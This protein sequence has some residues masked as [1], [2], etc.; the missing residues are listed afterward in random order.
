M[1]I[2]LLRVTVEG[3][4]LVAD[5]CKRTADSLKDIEK[6]KII[7]MLVVN[8][9]SS[10]L[11]HIYF[12]FELKN[13]SIA[14]ARELLEHRIASHTARS[15]RYCLEKDSGFV[16][17]PGLKEEDT[18][19]FKDL[20]KNAFDNYSKMYDYLIDRGYSQSKAREFARYLLPL[21]TNCTYIWTINVRSLINFFGLRLCVR[22]S[23]EMRELAKKIHDIVVMEYPN[24]F[25][26]IGCRGVNMGVCPENEARPTSCP[27]KGVIPTK[28]EVLK[29][30]GIK[31]KKCVDILKR[32]IENL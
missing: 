30:A 10:A 21:G 18:K 26:N 9:Y 6:D 28:K 13:I 2:K 19:Y 12:T 3:N 22:A 4:D 15:T 16:I 24:I 29:K 32:Q 11:E 7:E 17:P 25:K 1:E 20:M 23:P 14:I 31:Q 8:D 5:A 27:L